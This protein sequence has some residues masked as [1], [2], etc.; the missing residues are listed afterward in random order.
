MIT[1]RHAVSASSSSVYNPLIDSTDISLTG[2]HIV[3]GASA[4][5][6]VV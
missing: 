2:K 1:K 4:C 6:V 3:S 5:V